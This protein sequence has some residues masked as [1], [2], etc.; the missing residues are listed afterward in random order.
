[1]NQRVTLRMV[2]R[3]DFEAV[4]VENGQEAVE[5]VRGGEFDLVL[6]DCQMPELDGFSATAQ[7]RRLGPRG[8][9]P[10]I[11]LTA[12]AMQ[13][14]RERC[15]D[16]GMNDYLTKPIRAADLEQALEK[17]MN[18]DSTRPADTESNAA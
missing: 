2:E 14:D 15:I 17:W 6:M 8:I 7:I 13:G 11:A 10:I 12:N 4:V 5:A 3:A 16:S 9:L 1:M 18:I